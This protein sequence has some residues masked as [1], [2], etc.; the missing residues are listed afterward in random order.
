MGWSWRGLWRAERAPTSPLLWPQE[1][2][3]HLR[4]ISCTPHPFYFQNRSDP[5]LTPPSV[6]LSAPSPHHLRRG[7][8]APGLTVPTCLTVLSRQLQK[9]PYRKQTD[10]MILTLVNSSIW[11]EVGVQ[12]H[13][14][15]CGYPLLPAPFTDITVLLLLN[16][17]GLF[18][19][20][21]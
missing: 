14:L 2:Q 9:H 16:C 7:K 12:V 21:N 19:K 10:L 11:Y 3:S 6:F 1:A 8:H 13:S 5:L 17:V 18:V 15:T 20:K 4:L